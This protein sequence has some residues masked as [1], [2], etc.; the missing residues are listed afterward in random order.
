[1]SRLLTSLPIL[2]HREKVRAPRREAQRLASTYI[3]CERFG[4]GHSFAA[5]ARARPGTSSRWTRATT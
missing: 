4:L 2:T 1:M 3:L 5:D